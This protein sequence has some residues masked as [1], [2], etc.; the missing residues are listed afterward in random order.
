MALVA[1]YRSPEPARSRLFPYPFN[2]MLSFGR[3]YGEMRLSSRPA[4]AYSF[5]VGGN[6]SIRYI[7]GSGA[8]DPRLLTSLQIKCVI[9][10]GIPLFS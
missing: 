2:T 10:A 6:D 4:I 9:Y 7:G 5:D 1:T 8:A 3:D